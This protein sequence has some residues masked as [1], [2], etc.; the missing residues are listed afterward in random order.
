MILFQ[1]SCCLFAVILTATQA[2]QTL[3]SPQPPDSS[4][5]STNQVDL[6]GEGLSPNQ[7]NFFPG[8]AESDPNTLQDSPQESTLL[9]NG[10][11]GITNVLSPLGIPIPN[12]FPNW[13]PEFPDPE[14]IL[15]WLKK[16]KRPDC[17]NGQFLFCCQ[18]GPRRPLLDPNTP[19]ESAERM[20]ESQTRIRECV[21]CR[22]N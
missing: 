3:S 22:L 2:A 8:P 4:E 12:I 13:F 1:Y 5:I 10:K 18:L 7:F 16:P 6:Q 17:D 14:G 20:A 21:P 11:D 9:F 19:Y 15:R